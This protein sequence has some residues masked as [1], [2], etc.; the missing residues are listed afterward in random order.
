MLQCPTEKIHG[1][2]TDHVKLFA[3]SPLTRPVCMSV[4]EFEVSPAHLI[5]IWA[6]LR[7]QI[8]SGAADGCRGGDGGGDGCR[9]NGG[10]GCSNG[11]SLGSGSGCGTSIVGVGWAS[12]LTLHSPV[13]TNQGLGW[14]GHE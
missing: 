13:E 4:D 8:A 10:V 1:F 14:A 11:A 3:T 9:G 7:S 12:V 6:A 5:L 2:E